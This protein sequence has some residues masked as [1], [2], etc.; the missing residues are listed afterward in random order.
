MLNRLL[1]LSKAQTRKFATVK[2]IEVFI[3]G[4]SKMVD[5]RMT[6]FQACH[7][8]GVVVPRF[9]YH[10]KLSIAGNC[11][12]CLVEV[13]KAPKPI[14]SCA[15]QVM[16]GM[17]I[18][19]KSE[20]T[21]NARGAVM[22][23][24]LA[25]HPLDCP[26]C[27]QGGECDLQ[28]ISVK[29]GY[30]TGRYNEYKRAVQDKNLGPLIST[31]M[32][33]CIHCTRCVRFAEEVTG[34]F[35]LGTVGR[36]KETEIGTYVEK[37]VTSE[38][39]GNLADLC[40]VGAL[41]HGP[42]AFTSRPWELQKTNS[43]DLM[44]AIVAPVMFNSRGPELMRSLPR[45]HENVNEEWIS[46]KSRY[47]YD[48]LKRQRLTYPLAR[49]ESTGQLEEVMWSDALSRVSQKLHELQKPNEEIIGLVGQFNSVETVAAF[50]DFMSRLNADSIMF[51][52]YPIKGTQRSDYLFNRAIPEI[53]ELDVLVLVGCNPK[54]ESP[55]LNA[56]ILKAVKHKGLKVYKIGA[57]EDLTYEYTHLGTS[58]S[59]LNEVCNAKHPFSTVLA[60]A[61]NAHFIV[62][63]TLSRNF[64]E[65]N[66][67]ATNLQKLCMSL[68]EPGRY[69][70]SGILHQFVGPI[71][72]YEL[73]INYKSID[74]ISTP[75][76]IYNI[77]NDSEDLI[78]A[79]NARNSNAFVVYQGTNG[80][81]GASY[82]DVILPAAAW[83]ET[84]GTYVSL[85]GRSQ[86]GRLIVPP[87]ALAKDDWK[88]IR[89]LSEEYGEVL[90]FDSLEELRY[91]VAELCPHLLKYDYIEPYS[92][93]MSESKGLK[94]LE[95]ALFV[96]AVDNY[97][98]TD[99][100]S[101]SSVVMAK[102]SAAFNSTKMTNFLK[103][104]WLK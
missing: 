71:S 90:N 91:R 92:R 11:R 12:M 23:F 101:R 22:E 68:T 48:G 86:L 3:N 80:D 94:D 87:P 17:R 59:T 24:L 85:E 99:A 50:K 5:S 15:A 27:D 47:A 104:S 28:D 33:R 72:G 81:I 9:C 98:K 38:L 74:E 54:Y 97:Y 49:S 4:E 29:Y 58:T 2:E 102:C 6:I 46:D 40:P 82:A 77:G 67:L 70:T 93:L 64:E 103:A 8:A 36:G 41:T 63:S 30:E 32:T 89:A 66:T 42:Y 18:N 84:D 13:E 78:K 51:D 7:Y 31:Y 60:N 19:T 65:T 21:R 16:P 10:E 55:V 45:V 69:I 44:E 57:P 83:T 75:K 20:Y 95:D 35:D 61:K 37:M 34:T 88:I 100:V 39:S 73:G 62:S 26:I 53:E 56:R 43:V 25:N 14:A 1:K 52:K 96:S 79:L 76:F